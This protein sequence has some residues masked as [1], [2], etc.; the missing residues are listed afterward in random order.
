MSF[1]RKIASTFRIAS[2]YTN[3]S[4][5]TEYMKN[6]IHQLPAHFHTLHTQTQTVWAESS[7]QSM[8]QTIALNQLQVT[9]SYHH[10]VD[11]YCFVQKISGTSRWTVMK[12]YT[13]KH[14]P[15]QMNYNF[16]ET[17]IFPPAPSSTQ[18]ITPSISCSLLC[19]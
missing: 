12:F 19:V 1:A 7:Q 16:G 4:N 15:L 3:T 6:T 8:C 2:E 9:L 10:E 14:V 5:W 18:K 17:L 13:D 11:I